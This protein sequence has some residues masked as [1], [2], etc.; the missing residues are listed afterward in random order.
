[1]QYGLAFATSRSNGGIGPVQYILGMFE[2]SAELFFKRML[3]SV[4]PNS[5][6]CLLSLQHPF[7]NLT[8]PTV[9]GVQIIVELLH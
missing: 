2:M 1:M 8:D 7:Q 5:F 6:G 3:R 4:P 9:I